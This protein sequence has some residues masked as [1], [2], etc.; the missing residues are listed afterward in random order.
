M[1][2]IFA[3]NKLAFNKRQAAAIISG[4]H[5]IWE[6]S[7]EID[8]PQVNRAFIVGEDLAGS[9]VTGSAITQGEVNLVGERLEV[10]HTPAAI[11]AA[12]A[13]GVAAAVL[14][15]NRLDGQKG[16]ILVPPHCGLELWDVV[17]VVD[18]GVNQSG[19]YRVSGY[20]LEYDIAAGQY[21][22]HIDLSSP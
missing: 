8:I 7:Y 17:N 2:N 19:S 11:T 22:Q 9:L 6:A 18:I 15:K 12:V 5:I 4:M 3:F 20:A 14:G 13:A 16:K 21:Q 10:Q 1:F